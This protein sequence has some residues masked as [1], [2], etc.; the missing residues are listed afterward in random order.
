[1]NLQLTEEQ[2]SLRELYADLFAKESSSAQVRAAEPL[3]HDPILWSHLIEI[4]TL[5]IGV[6][7]E[8]G[9]AGA[10]LLELALFAEQAGRRVAPIPIAE[11]VAA[12]RLLARL[13]EQAV[14]DAMLEGE[15]LISIAHR[16]A[17]LETQLLVDGAIADAVVSL[18]NGHVVLSDRPE[19]VDHVRNVGAMPLAR[20]KYDSARQVGDGPAGAEAFSAALDEVRV[21]RAAALVGLAFEAIEMGAVYA[22]ERRAFGIPIGTYQAVAH[23]LADAVVAAD[24]AQ[25][26]VWKACWALT[27]GHSQ[28][29]A[30][31]CM[32]LIFA[33]QTAYAAAQH[34]LHIHGGY[35]FMEEYDIQLYFRRA[36]A[37][38]AAFADPRRELALL[39]DRKL[40][41]IRATANP[42]G[43]H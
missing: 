41:A 39:A 22:R 14:L 31:A 24:G 40:G 13:G 42:A 20:W 28:G 11:P 23:P 19:Q 7:E 2:R 15:A 30:L 5:G 10:G 9:G 17:R 37:W 43:V 38:H 12:A 1:M 35:G 33:G 34:S 32:A 25:L 18:T 21:L 36:K 27:T 8:Q 3:G 16:P 6:P 26:L 29:P 4:G